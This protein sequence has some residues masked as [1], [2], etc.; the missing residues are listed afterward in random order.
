MMQI[1]AAAVMT[2]DLNS[3]GM[4]SIRA[5]QFVTLPLR[6]IPFKK[7]TGKQICLMQCVMLGIGSL[8]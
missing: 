1:V 6:D 2:K 3:E 8:W 5:V 7:G 4:C